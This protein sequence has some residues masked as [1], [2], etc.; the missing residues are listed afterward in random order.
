MARPL[1]SRK[2]LIEFREYITAW[3]LREID[4]EFSAAGIPLAQST[5]VEVKSGARRHQVELY[6]ASLDLAKPSDTAKLLSV[7]ENVVSVAT[8]VYPDKARDLIAWIG[9]DGYTWDGN[10]LLPRAPSGMRHMAGKLDPVDAQS[11]HDGIRRI[12]NSIDDDP[13]LA[14]GAAKELVE[15]TCKTILDSKGV[16]YA[17]DSDLS[18]LMKATTKILK[19]TPDDIPAVAKGSD[20]IKRTLHSLASVVGSIAE[21][22]TLYGT[23]HGKSGKAKGLQP[24][25]ARLVVGATS[26]LATF[27]W[28]TFEDRRP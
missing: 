17:K 28:D 12:E 18:E 14:I 24:R 9:K 5:N 15:S 2:T 3:V 7:F 25:H 4:D 27:L 8:R 26:S 10:H 1:I 21:L 22:R 23:G 13:A 16:P 11:I 6:Y 20:L 19:L